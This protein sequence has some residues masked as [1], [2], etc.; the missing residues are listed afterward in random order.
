M[1]GTATL[2]KKQTKSKKK[3]RN[4][5][6]L[7]LLSMMLP[8]FIYLL[9]NNY[10]PMAGLV[11]AF[12]RFNYSKGIWGSDWC[13]F[14]NFTYLFRTNDALNIVRNTLGYNLTFILLGNL[15]AVTVAVMLNFLR[16]N[17]NKKVY[18]TLILI[19]YL[20]SMVVVSYI[21]YG[22]LSQDNGFLN[23]LFVKMGGEKISWYTETKYWPFIL[24][25]VNL[26]KGFGY[27]SILYYATVIGIDSS[28]YEAATV[29]G[30]NPVSYTH[31]NGQRLFL[32]PEEMESGCLSLH[33]G[34]VEYYRT[35]LC[36]DD[37]GNGC[38]NGCK[39]SGDDTVCLCDMP[40]RGSGYENPQF[41]A[42]FYHAF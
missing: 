34:A 27:S 6:T 4:K 31:L 18:Q 2:A 40:D 13:G 30:A 41:Y 42:D 28:L 14:S 1:A 17:M 32:F 20:I 9:I 37:Y 33:S 8:G 25:I 39:Y 10:I 19:P 12:K 7:A 35:R 38:G 3:G 26:W 22:F 5:M 15:L 24:V 29:D 36:Y 11:I 23:S 21:V 16:G